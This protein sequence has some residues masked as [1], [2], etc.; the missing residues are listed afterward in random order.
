MDFV[1]KLLFIGLIMMAACNPGT[2]SSGLTTVKV[3]EVE[4]VANYTY[5]LVKSKGP[6]YWIAVPTMVAE[7]GDTYQYQGGMLMEDFHSKELDR[8]FDKVLFL[9]TLFGATESIPGTQAAHPAGQAAGHPAVQE[10]T[11]GSTVKTEK[12]KVNVEAAEGT[13]P[14]S[15]LYAN[16]TAFDGKTIRVRGEVVKYN[17]AIMERNWVHIQDGTEYEGKFDLTVT[18]S[19]SFNVG[20]IVT[21]EGVLAINKDFGYGYNYEILLE[22]ATAVQ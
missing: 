20:S 18:S 17:A 6:E 1:K 2:E 8:T 21:I 4:Q 16:P 7:V 15:E 3:L 12:A 22:K 11:P 5:L 19:E 13:T 10:V 14:I 9:E